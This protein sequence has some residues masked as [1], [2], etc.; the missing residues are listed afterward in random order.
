MKTVDLPPVIP[1]AAKLSDR[2][3]FSAHKD[4]RLRIRAPVD[5]EYLWEF[6]RFGMHQE[7]RRRII[8]ATLPKSL[9]KRYDIDYIR[10]P[11][12]LFSD[13]TVEDRDDILGP[14]LNE[15]MRDAAARS[16]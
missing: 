12:L 16:G 8:V 15:L 13:E 7:H 3:F 5:G 2:L 10:I 4:R 14:I 11:M 1:A 9:S 6:R